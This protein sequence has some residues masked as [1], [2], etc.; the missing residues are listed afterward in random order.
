MHESTE[1]Q[2]VGALYVVATPIG[3]LKDI[4]FRA[5]EI[6]NTVN[7]IA[8]EDTRHTRKLLSH[9]QIKAHLVSCH[10][11]NESFR[12]PMLLQKLQSGESV[13]LVSDAGTPSVSDPGYRLVAAAIAQGLSVIPIPGVSAAVTAL[14]ASG[15]PSDSFYFVGFLPASSS[16]RRAK[17][18]GISKIRSTLVFYESPR[19]IAQTMSDILQTLGDRPAVIARE[20]TKIH[21]EFL[22]GSVAELNAK[23]RIVESMKGEITLLIGPPPDSDDDADHDQDD[24]LEA[25]IESELKKGGAG[26]SALA[27]SLSKIYKTPKNLIYQKILEIK[28]SMDQNVIH[29]EGDE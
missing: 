11:H 2:G 18:E 23:M 8:A 26:A 9:F 7:T 24:Q 27:R 17:L 28:S 19:R 6:L 12:I 22:R 1:Q 15:L 29:G 25:R 13:A 5:I 14:C 4:T 10:E 16:R 21:E 20:M 3:N